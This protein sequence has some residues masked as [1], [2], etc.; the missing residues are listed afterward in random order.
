MDL[1]TKFDGVWKGLTALTGIYFL[2]IIEHC[3]GMFKHY[4]DHRVREATGGGGGR[5]A[6]GNERGVTRLCRSQGRKK[7]NEEGKIG[8]KLSD[9]KLNRRSDAEW[10]HLKPLGEGKRRVRPFAS[11]FAGGGGG[12]RGFVSR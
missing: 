2:F 8:R 11:F 3:I 1:I 10:L 12:G 9:H 4:R 7:A 5:G 6:T